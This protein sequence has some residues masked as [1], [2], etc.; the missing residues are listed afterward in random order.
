MTKE[1]IL[2]DI[3]V[4]HLTTASYDREGRTT[5]TSQD[6]KRLV[7]VYPTG[8]I[9]LSVN[10]FYA[11]YI[12]EPTKG[13]YYTHDPTK[14]GRDYSVYDFLGIT[15]K[16]EIVN[17]FLWGE[18]SDD[19]LLRLDGA[20]SFPDLEGLPPLIPVP[21]FPYEGENRE[22]VMTDFVKQG[23]EEF[24]EENNKEP[25]PFSS[26]LIKQS[27]KTLLCAIGEDPN[28]EGLIDT[29]NRVARFWEEFIDYDP[30]NIKTSFVHNGL[31]QMVVV[32]DIPFFSLCEHHLLPFWGTLS[33]AYIANDK[34]LGL[35]KLPRIVQKYA[36]KL[37]LQEQ[38]CN[39]IAL[40]LCTLLGHKNVAVVGTATHTCMV[41]RGI[42]SDGIMKTSVMW[43][44]F[45]SEVETRAEF[46]TLLQE[47]R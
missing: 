11:L 27:T 32:G 41:M 4:V 12:Y 39:Q 25:A 23:L 40:E 34:V 10:L 35:S 6:E 38:L 44:M 13:V 47:G 22:I 24:E 26:E 7:V 9:G 3:A 33:I 45:R 5:L 14:E 36:H 1:Y 42:K 18:I 30:G 2:G 20:K 17:T 19:E 31:D 16:E 15:D 29:P 28:R 43:G 46:F 21:S 37:Q 8:L